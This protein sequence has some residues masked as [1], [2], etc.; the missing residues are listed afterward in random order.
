MQRSIIKYGKKSDVSLI[1]YCLYGANSGISLWIFTFPFEV[2]KFRIQADDLANRKYKNI[3]ST[4]KFIHRD[5]VIGEFF[6]GIIPCLVRAPFGN[7]LTFLT[8]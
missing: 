8:F 5:S 4:F 1:Y 6:K 2:V 7:S 3:M